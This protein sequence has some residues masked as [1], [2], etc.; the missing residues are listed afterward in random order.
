[1]II[2]YT[3][4][5]EYNNMIY[6][7]KGNK[8]KSI[9]TCKTHHYDSS[10]TFLNNKKKNCTDFYKLRYVKTAKL[11]FDKKVWNICYL[12]FGRFLYSR[13]KSFVL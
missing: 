6:D 5:V 11:F 1:M 7:D 12:K 2:L 9:K 13:K 10:H 8:N 3:S 4:T